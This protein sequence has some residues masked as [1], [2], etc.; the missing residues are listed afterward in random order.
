VQIGPTNPE[1]SKL[2]ARAKM[3]WHV[4]VCS[5]AWHSARPDIRPAQTL[6]RG[7]KFGYS[8]DIRGSGQDD[9]MKSS[10]TDCTEISSAAVVWPHLVSS[11]ARISRDRQPDA[12][13]PVPPDPWRKSASDHSGLSN[14]QGRTGVDGSMPLQSLSTVGK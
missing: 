11:S 13:R 14:G 5:S 8:V 4:T 2:L 7:G 6:K 9:A 1:L 12:A 3:H 10:V